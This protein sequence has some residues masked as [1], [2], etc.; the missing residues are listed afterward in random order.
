MELSVQLTP[1]PLSPWGKSS[2]FPL[3]RRLGGAE[4]RF[5]RGGE[6][7]NSHHC[8]SWELNPDRS[9][10]SLVCVLTGSVVVVNFGELWIYIR[11][12]HR[13]LLITAKGLENRIDIRVYIST[14]VS[15]TSSGIRFINNH[16]MID[17]NFVFSA[18]LLESIFVIFPAFVESCNILM[19]NSSC[20]T[21]KILKTLYNSWLW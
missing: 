20:L 17:R 10:R 1:R 2:R 3:D 16:W 21:I 13:L 6:E 9:D 5:G 14:T 7:K 12:R 15:E 18:Y 4:R 19:I 8:P 11:T